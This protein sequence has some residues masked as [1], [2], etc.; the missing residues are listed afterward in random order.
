M[1]ILTVGKQ[2]SLVLILLPPVSMRLIFTVELN[3]S[4]ASQLRP[5]FEIFSVVCY[6]K[7]LLEHKQYPQ[8]FYILYLAAFV[9][10]GQNWVVATETV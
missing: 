4:G 6:Y 10:Q 7:V 9:L 3:I 1:L 8:P 5:V 2:N